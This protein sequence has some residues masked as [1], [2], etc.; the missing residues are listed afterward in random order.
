M[1]LV[2]TDGRWSVKRRVGERRAVVREKHFRSRGESTGPG[3][4]I[5]DK[6][7]TV[8]ASHAQAVARS[9]YVKGAPGLHRQN[10]GH[11]E[12]LEDTSHDSLIPISPACAQR[13]LPDR[14]DDSDVTDVVIGI[15]AI[16]GRQQRIADKIHLSGCRHD[17]IVGVI[18]GMRPGVGTL[19]LE[20]VREPFGQFGL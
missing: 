16:Q 20:P 12:S 14:I 2:T 3:E 7:R 4:R 1:K 17:W 5:T 13:Q 19:Y 8:D 9:E 11:L 15:A 18:D 6:I 10:S